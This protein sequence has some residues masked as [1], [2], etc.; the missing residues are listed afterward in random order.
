LGRG[1]HQGEFSRKLIDQPATAVVL[2]SR[3]SSV[4]SGRDFLPPMIHPV[5]PRANTPTIT[6]SALQDLS[7]V[8]RFV[9]SVLDSARFGPLCETL[10]KP[11]LRAVGQPFGSLAFDDHI[12]SP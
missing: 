8:W 5:L 4:E 9:R 6:D 10:Q 1:K 12:L 2:G 7:D 3:S 11:T